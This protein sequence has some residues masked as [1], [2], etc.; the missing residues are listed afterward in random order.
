MG[1]VF[2]Q[3]QP[4]NTALQTGQP[5]LTK[6]RRKRQR[7]YRLNH[8]FYSSSPPLRISKDFGKT[9]SYLTKVRGETAMPAPA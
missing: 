9:A 2:S 3:Q 6:V 1:E 7:V 5:T 4:R 8:S